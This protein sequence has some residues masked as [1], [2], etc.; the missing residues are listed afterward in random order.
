MQEDIFHHRTFSADLSVHQM[1]ETKLHDK[2][3]Y[4]K[5]IGRTKIEQQRVG[6]QPAEHNGTQKTKFY[7]ESN[8]A[9]KQE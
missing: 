1:N 4:C 6:S 7:L 9:I 5:N 3:E 8:F 2:N